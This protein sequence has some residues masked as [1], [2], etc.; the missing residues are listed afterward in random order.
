MKITADQIRAKR[1]SLPN[2]YKLDRYTHDSLGKIAV[3]VEELD[4]GR[5]CYIPMVETAVRQL[6]EMLF[7]RGAFLYGRFVEGA[8][9]SMSKDLTCFNLVSWCDKVSRA[10]E[11][12][13]KVV[14]NPPA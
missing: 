12:Y 7:N 5:Q 13:K 11:G 14:S 9:T 6:A 2:H 8:I 3:L 10:Y 4:S 1:D